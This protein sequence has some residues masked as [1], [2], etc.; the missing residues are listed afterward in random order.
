MSDVNTCFEP[1]VLFTW[2]LARYLME[3]KKRKEKSNLKSL[4]IHFDDDNNDY[5]FLIQRL[6]SIYI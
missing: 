3:Q 5:Y 4:K 2:N 6:K 1:C